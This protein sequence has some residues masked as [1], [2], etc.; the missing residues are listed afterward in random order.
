MSEQD[1]PRVTGLGGVFY[2][3]KDT[4]ATR[5]WYRDMLGIDGPYG[6][7]LAWSE[8]PKKNPYSL[9]SQFADDQYIKPGKGGF[10]INLRVHDLDGFVDQLKSKGVDVLDTADEGYAKFAWILDPNDIKIELWEQVIDELPP[11]ES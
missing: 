3:A 11:E 1:K 5:E 4:A 8:E 7:Q 2:V 6:P 10:M 9:I